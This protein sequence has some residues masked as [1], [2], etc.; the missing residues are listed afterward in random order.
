MPENMVTCRYCG[1]PFLADR[2]ATHEENCGSNPDNM[3]PE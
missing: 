3:N 2:I 1:N